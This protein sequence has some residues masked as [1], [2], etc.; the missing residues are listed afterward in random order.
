LPYWLVGLVLQQQQQQEA[1]RTRL[2]KQSGSLFADG[3]L[4]LG[5]LYIKLGQIVS[6]REKLLPTEWK[7]ALERLQD[8]VPS[9][10]GQA[11][12]D[13]AYASVGSKQK[14]DRLF[15]NFTT[16]PL[17][18]ASLGQ[19]HRAVL[20]GTNDAVAVKLQR[21]YLREIYD[22][23]FELLLNI[24][25]IVDR[26]VGKKAQVGG[27]AQSWTEIFTNAKTILYREIDYRD[28][29]DNAIRFAQDF[30][31]GKNGTATQTQAVTRTNEPLPSAAP[32][33]RTPYVYRNVSSE[34]ILV[35]EYVPSI[36]ITDTEELKKANVTAEEK[37]Y[38]ADS[39]ARTYLRQFCV[40][41]FFSTD[42]H[43]GN[44]GV[45]RVLDGRP[46][47]VFYDFGQACEL[48]SDQAD[49]I[50]DVIE[51]IVDSDATR[52]VHAFE[53]MGVLTDDVN[54]DKVRAKVQDNFEKGLVKVRKKK[55]KKAGYKFNKNSARVSP[56]KGN[57]T[58]TV[59][60]ATEVDSEVMKYFKLPAEYAFVARAISQMDGVGKSL[61]PDFDF[62]SSAAPN[63]VEI[64]GATTYLKDEFNKWVNSV[65]RR[66]I[67]CWMNVFNRK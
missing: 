17:A 42:P 62:I 53:K 59:N 46:R 7:E 14:F 61:D 49:G 45:E 50:L 20:H 21:P 9:R 43:P 34:K 64:K 19:V 12:L 52:C 8:R 24:A 26:F 23:D 2:L 25:T 30:G 18:A 33:L 28:E 31:L 47:L 32:W 66:V 54:V 35:M 15:S 58:S 11:A 27:V 56:T 41:K 44:L 13:L 51:A 29:A 5:P 57:S 3:L 48:N 10:S 63:I 38:L 22:Q 67:D 1:R 37:E 55:L 16:T 65:Q 4:Q 36:K 6:C 39:L 40:N 60:N